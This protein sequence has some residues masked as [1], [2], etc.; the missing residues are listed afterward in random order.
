M[1]LSDLSPTE[2]QFVQNTL[3]APPPS[4][5]APQPQQQML[6]D[7][8]LRAMAESGFLG[9]EGRFFSAMAQQQDRQKRL[10]MAKEASRLTGLEP[11]FYERVQGFAQVDPE[12]FSSSPVQQAL[13]VAQSINERA[14]KKAEEAK[15]VKSARAAANLTGSESDFYKRVQKLAQEDPIA[16]ASSPVQ[17]MISVAQSASEQARK[18]AEETRATQAAKNAASLTGKESDFYE[19]LQKLAQEDPVA[20]SSPQVQRAISVAQSSSEQAKKK[21]EEERLTK[22]A[23]S[24]SNLTG[25]EPDFYQKIQR[26]AQ[27]DPVAFASP[28]VQQA[29]SFAQSVSEQE[30][31]KS[32][33]MRSIQMAK[34]A[35]SLTGGE[36]DFYERVQALAQVDPESFASPLVQRALSPAQTMQDRYRKATEEFQAAQVFGQVRQ[37][38]PQ[39]IEELQTRGDPTLFKFRDVAE[40]V[41]KAKTEASDLLSQIP[42]KLQTNLQGASLPQVKTAYEKYNRAIPPVL[43]KKP[44]ED[45]QTVADLAKRWKAAFK[46][47]EKAIKAGTMPTPKPGE[48]LPS[49]TLKRQIVGILSPLNPD[50][51][52]SDEIIDSIAK[53][54][55][56]ILDEEDPQEILKK[57][58]Q[59]VEGSR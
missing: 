17:Q 6:V 57:R 54:S 30:R 32:E 35:A 11:D 20:F 55:A 43:R 24:A 1:A 3:L 15:L 34:V 4:Q 56:L 51:E 41:S 14:R 58:M 29:L 2:L 44:F 31:K 47:E 13:S 46:A 40:Q 18:L 23:K 59:E 8:Q 45:Q 53:S 9:E 7:D 28:P 16:F 33:G 25:R 42:Q 26:L 22:A 48:S 49:E 12:A 39:Q 36:P 21:A 52:F 50:K 10:Q 37:M 19:R 5:F 27:E 38:T